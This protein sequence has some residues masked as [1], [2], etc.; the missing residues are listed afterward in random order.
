MDGKFE[1]EIANIHLFQVAFTVFGAVGGP[2]LGAFFIGLYMPKISGRAAC[3]GLV[4]ST[5]TTFFIAF[6]AMFVHVS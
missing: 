5:V 1:R 3:A 2:V 6:G 4:L